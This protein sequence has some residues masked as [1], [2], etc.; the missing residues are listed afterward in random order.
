MRPRDRRRTPTHPSRR[1]AQARRL[2]VRLLRRLP[3]DPA[4]LRGRAARARRARCEI[5]YFPEATRA[6]VEGPYDLVPRRGLD[7][8]PRGRRADPAGPRRCPGTLVTIGA[9]A[10]SGR[11][12]GAAQLRRRRGVPLASSTPTRSTSRRSTARPPI[13]AHVHGRLRAARLPDR[14][15]PAARGPRRARC[16]AGRPRIPAYSVCV[17]CK[18]RGNV[19]VA[20]AARDAVPRAGHPGRLRRAVPVLRP[21]LLRLLRPAGHRE[22]R[23]AGRPAACRLGMPERRRD[24]GLPH[25]QRRRRAVPP[26]RA[27]A[28][29]GRRG[30]M[31]HKLTRRPGAQRRHAGPGR[32]RGRACTSA[33]ATARSPTS[34]LRI[35]EPPRFFEAFLR[36]RAYTEPPDITARICGICPVAYQMSACLAIE[37]ACG[38]DVPEE[39]RLTAPAALLRGV[40]REPRA[41]H[42]P[43]ARPGLPRLRRRHRDGR[44]TTRGSSSAGCG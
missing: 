22:H 30:P 17:E 4:Q 21:R 11:H 36:G 20:V 7:H 39:I 37:D 29:D 18:R 19:C 3:A 2:E 24:A 40:D 31:T 9:C 42:L 16:R 43:A 32:G 8:H 15:A 27:C 13:A 5:A 1:P 12:P 14:Q 26:A 35:Y 41:A 34:Q 38:V 23:V 28:H 6:V 25:V 44:A 33:S 10:T